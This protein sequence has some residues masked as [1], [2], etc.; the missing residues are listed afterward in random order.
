MEGRKD[1]SIGKQ[2]RLTNAAGGACR[3]PTVGAGIYALSVI[4]RRPTG[5]EAVGRGWGSTAAAAAT[6]TTAGIAT[7]SD[8][9]HLQLAHL[10]HILDAK[11]FHGC[12]F[13]MAKKRLLFSK[14]FRLRLSR[15]RLALT[16]AI[17][18]AGRDITVRTNI[19]ALTA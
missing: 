13:I 1:P 18:E 8:A 15:G 19:G 2:S 6:S 7:R 14:G 16:G 11:L 4:P 12:K 10:L 3:D 9:L 17:G 5:V